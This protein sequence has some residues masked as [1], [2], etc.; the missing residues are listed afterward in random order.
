ML[1]CPV[2]LK[3]QVVVPEKPARTLLSDPQRFNFYPPIFS[4]PHLGIMS[5]TYD[6]VQLP[7][8]INTVLITGAGGKGLAAFCRLMADFEVQVLSANNSLSCFS[9]S[10]PLSSS[11]PPTLSNLP[12]LAWPTGPS[13][14]RSKRIL[15]MLRRSRRSSK[16]KISEESLPFSTFEALGHLSD[17]H[18][19]LAESCPVAPNQIL[20]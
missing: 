2:Y 16:G 17:T 20:S 10:N 18:E 6:A 13:S 7:S 4:I 15:G 3:Q 12:T 11:S 8:H 14:R 19:R 1:S 9:S 5:P